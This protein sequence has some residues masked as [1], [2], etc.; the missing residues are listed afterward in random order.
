VSFLFIDRIVEIERGRRIVAIH[1]PDP[2]G[3]YFVHHFPLRPMFPG[4]LLLECVAQV[5][6]ILLE[7]SADFRLKVLPAYIQNAKF[8]RPVVPGDELHVQ[9]VTES[10]SQ[11]GAVLRGEIRQQDGQRCMTVALGMIT[12]PLTEFFAPGHMP[13]YREAYARWLEG[14]ITRGFEDHPLEVLARAA[15]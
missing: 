9:L 6:S 7:I 11:A 15:S 8:R 5:G 4:S 12:A 10:S 14:T 13:A 1:R 2:N 3:W